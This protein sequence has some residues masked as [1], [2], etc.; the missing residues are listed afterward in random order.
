MN[1]IGSKL[2]PRFEEGKTFSSL[3]YLLIIFPINKLRWMTLYTTQQLVK[4][5]EEGTSKGG[6]ISVLHCHIIVPLE[7]DL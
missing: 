6:I 2:T 7:K 5:G 3:D 4:H 1:T